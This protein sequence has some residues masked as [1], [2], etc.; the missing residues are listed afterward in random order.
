MVA[1]PGGGKAVSSHRGGSCAGWQPRAEVMADKDTAEI[2][3]GTA[4]LGISDPPI[5]EDFIV[6]VQ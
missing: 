6:P 2:S 3:K 4:H 1:V 5:R